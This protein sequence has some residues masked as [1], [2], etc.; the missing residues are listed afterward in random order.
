MCKRVPSQLAQAVHSLMC[1]RCWPWGHTRSVLTN[2]LSCRLARDAQ[3]PPAG[4]VDVV[5]LCFPLLDPGRAVALCVVSKAT[6]ASIYSQLL[7]NPKVVKGW[8]R[9][10]A[11][12]ATAQRDHADMT[13]DYDQLEDEFR[14]VYAS[15]DPRV[16]QAALK[17]IRWLITVAKDIWG[18]DYPQQLDLPGALLAAGQDATVIS[19][20]LQGLPAMPPS[21]LLECAKRRVRIGNLTGKLHF[22]SSSSDPSDLEKLLLVFWEFLQHTQQQQPQQYPLYILE[23]LHH[24]QQLRFQQLQQPPLALSPGDLHSFTCLLLSHE[25]CTG[26]SMSNMLQQPAVQQWSPAQVHELLLLAFQQPRSGTYAL[27]YLTRLQQAQ[28]LSWK[29]LQQLAVA[30]GRHGGAR[31]LLFLLSA[32]DANPPSELLLIAEALFRGYH[33]REEEEQLLRLPAAREW[34]WEDVLEMI[35]ESLP[36]GR[37]T[38]NRVGLLVELPGA[39]QISF[40]QVQELFSMVSSIDRCRYVIPL[41]KLP[42]AAHLTTDALQETLRLAATVDDADLVEVAFAHPAAAGLPSEFLLNQ[43][44]RCY[45]DEP[46]RALPMFLA[47]PRVQGAPLAAVEGALLDAMGFMEYGSYRRDLLMALPVV[48]AMSGAEVVGFLRVALSAIRKCSHVDGNY[49]RP[50]LDLPGAQEFTPQQLVWLLQQLLLN[51]SGLPSYAGAIVTAVKVLSRV[52]AARDIAAADI[53]KLIEDAVA[54]GSNG[55]EG[56]SVDELV[57]LAELPCAVQLELPTLLLLLHAAA[58]RGLLV[59][60]TKLL[61]LPVVQAGLSSTHVGELLQV[62]AA[63]GTRSGYVPG[64]FVFALLAAVPGAAQGLEANVVGELLRALLKHGHAFPCWFTGPDEG[65]RALLLLPGVEHL[66][67]DVV[68]ELLELPKKQCCRELLKKH[69]P[70]AGQ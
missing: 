38:F 58:A 41:L 30:A 32:K 6:K 11:R 64:G 5:E 51:E 28:Q 13:E 8:L 42:A 48:Q 65:M 36:C 7:E 53:A 23:Y 60:P 10:A 52:P 37:D 54:A 26:A 45:P 27:N 25:Y 47:H 44:M 69:L 12:R 31:H 2:L 9:D 55:S 56:V 68:K 29:Q 43:I 18:D 14:P 59:A 20:L 50:F 24:Q 16:V 19:S 49:L 34:G 22:V 4:L 67:G 33:K 3:T 61:Q 21:F 15:Q 70:A 66:S 17:D 46:N 63:A 62:A 57:D 40:A 1:T 35:R 39:K